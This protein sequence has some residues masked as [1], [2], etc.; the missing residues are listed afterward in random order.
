MNCVFWKSSIH[1]A[2]CKL[3]S[4]SEWAST[5]CSELCG[6]EQRCWQK[7]VDLQVAINRSCHAIE[8]GESLTKS[9]LSYST[10][11]RRMRVV[12]N[13]PSSLVLVRHAD[14]RQEERSEPHP[15]ANLTPGG[16]SSI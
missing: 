1:I 2:L 4:K 12:R 11:Q 5:R 9:E 14:D 6:H 15:L 13:I 3:Q 8:L 10:A 7:F 16:G